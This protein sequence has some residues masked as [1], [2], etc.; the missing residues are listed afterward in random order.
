[1]DTPHYHTFW[2]SFAIFDFQTQSQDMAGV[3]GIGWGIKN[4]KVFSS[5]KKKYFKNVL[6]FFLHF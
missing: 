1:M 2:L 3:E 5:L 6:M 4:V